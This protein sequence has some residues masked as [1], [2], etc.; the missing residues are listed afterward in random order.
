MLATAVPDN[1][2]AYEDV[3]KA[4]DD[5]GPVMATVGKVVSG[6][7]APAMTVHVNDWV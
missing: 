3:E 1:G 7:G 6:V 2:R 4:D 5:D